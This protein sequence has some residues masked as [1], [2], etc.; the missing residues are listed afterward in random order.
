MWKHYFKVSWRNLIQNKVYSTLNI[1][2]LTLGIASFLLILNYVLVEI[3][4]DNFHKD[5]SRIYR[6]RYD[7][8]SKGLLTNSRVITYRDAGPSMKED[9]PEVLDFTRML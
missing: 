1:F 8:F 9:L 6:I 7:H 3:S 4:Y 2:G 5:N